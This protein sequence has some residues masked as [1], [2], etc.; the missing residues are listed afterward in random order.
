MNSQLRAGATALTSCP[1]SPRLCRPGGGRATKMVSHGSRSSRASARVA[2][3]FVGSGAQPA[4][5]GVAESRNLAIYAERSLRDSSTAFRSLRSLHSARND[6]RFFKVRH[7]QELARFVKR[8]YKVSY[9]HAFPHLSKQ[10]PR[11]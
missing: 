3:E 5:A 11:Q 8:L 7:Y 6:T 9:D 1:P 10:E 2:N 4:P